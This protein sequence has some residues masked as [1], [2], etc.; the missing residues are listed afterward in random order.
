[1]DNDVAC[2]DQ[3]PVAMG[4]ALDLGLAVSGIFEGAQQMVG[5]GADMPAGASGRDDDAVGER[6]FAFQIDE[7]DVDGL[8]VIQ[9]VQDQDFGGRQV[10]PIIPGP[11]GRRRRGDLRRE[12]FIVGNFGNG[13]VGREIAVQRMLLWA[14]VANM[15][16]AHSAGFGQAESRSALEDTDWKGAVR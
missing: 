4:Q 15:I 2:V 11:P 12:G 3:H 7:H 8:F 10:A 1:M 9:A 13:R 6:A 14:W 5:N 16:L